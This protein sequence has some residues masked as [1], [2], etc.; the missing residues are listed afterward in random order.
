MAVLDRAFRDLRVSAQ[1]HL[2]IVIIIALL[3]L[4]AM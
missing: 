4:I 2:I 1:L 3:R